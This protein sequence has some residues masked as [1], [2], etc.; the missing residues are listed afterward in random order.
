MIV[1]DKRR[2]FGATSADAMSTGG[3]AQTQT[4]VATPAPAPT[5]AAPA[6][7]PT[8]ASAGQMYSIQPV[9]APSAFGPGAVITMPA[10]APAPASADATL[11][12]PQAPSGIY[13]IPAASTAA[14]AS[15]AEALQAARDALSTTPLPEIPYTQQQFLAPRRMPAEPPP[16]PADMLMESGEDAGST[17][18]A[19]PEIPASK[20]IIDVSAPASARAPA[21]A[22]AAK[23]L[24]PAIGFGIAGFF[25][26]GPVGALIGAAAGYLLA[27]PKVAP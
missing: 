3:G 19:E 21:P 17:A 24:T 18:A 12:Q 8:P 27:K 16:T 20:Q 6:P 10:P 4:Q 25:A 1:T 5:P 9:P 22:A 23:P 26:G 7:A 13:R 15:A 2:R 11:T 14:P